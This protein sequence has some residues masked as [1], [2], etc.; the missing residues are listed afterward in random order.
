MYI[1]TVDKG[2]QSFVVIL[3][4]KIKSWKNTPIRQVIYGKVFINN[5]RLLHN[6]GFFFYLQPFIPELNLYGENIRIVLHNVG[7]L[8]LEFLSICLSQALP[9]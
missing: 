7:I 9:S 8:Y 4:F 2:F 1:L 6:V 5:R 3:Y